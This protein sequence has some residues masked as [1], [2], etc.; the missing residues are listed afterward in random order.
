MDGKQLSV[1]DKVAFGS[2]SIEYT[3][4][5]EVAVTLDNYSVR[6]ANSDIF[7]NLALTATKPL[8]ASAQ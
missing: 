8:S 4:S 7:L 6:L 2:F 1:G 5:H 3:S